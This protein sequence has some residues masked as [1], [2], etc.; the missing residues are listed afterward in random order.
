VEELRLIN[1]LSSLLSLFFR[2]TFLPVQACILFRFITEAQIFVARTTP[3]L[4]MISISAGVIN[5]PLFNRNP[6]KIGLGEVSGFRLSYSESPFLFCN[7][8]IN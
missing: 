1:N 5:L 4:S 3:R 8:G 6:C 7:P 2:E